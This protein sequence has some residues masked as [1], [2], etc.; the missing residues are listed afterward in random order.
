MCSPSPHMCVCEWVTSPLTAAY[1][2]RRFRGEWSPR[3]SSSAYACRRFVENGACTPT[4]VTPFLL[5]STHN[6]WKNLGI[7][8]LVYSC[9][10][11]GSKTLQKGYIGQSEGWIGLVL[12]LTLP[13]KGLIVLKNKNFYGML[14]TLET[15]IEECYSLW[16]KGHFFYSDGRLMFFHQSLSSVI[17]SRAEHILHKCHWV[18]GFLF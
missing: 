10:T 11:I 15:K 14:R 9:Q 7:F 17:I 4:Y 13:Q 1:A 8:S 12:T 16:T 3:K 2:C 6:F 5:C 18:K